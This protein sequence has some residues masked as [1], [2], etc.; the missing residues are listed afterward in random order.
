MEGQLR[1]DFTADSSFS[2]ATVDAAA[3]DNSFNDSGSGFPTLAAG[4]WIR[5][6]G[7]S[8]NPVNNGWHEVV[9]QVAG[10]IVVAGVTLIT[11]AVGDTITISDSTLVNGVV[12]KSYTLEKNMN[13]VTQFFGFTGC[14]VNTWSLVLASRQKVTGT[15]GVLGKAGALAATTL[16]S[17]AYTAAPTNL[18]LNASANVARLFEGGAV[19]G[20]GVFA[21][22][23]NIDFNQNLRVVDGIGQ[24]DAVDIG[25][26][27]FNTTG[28]LDALFANEVLFNKYMNSTESAINVAIEDAAG[29][30]YMVSFPAVV[31][32]NGDIV[33]VGNDDQII[34][35]MEWEAKMHA[36]QGIMARIDRTP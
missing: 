11:E 23:I 30:G 12:K 2:A 9:S 5:V 20:A 19:L 29:N 28:T 10:K 1:S 27:R 15:F 34:A 32:T 14:R 13:D 26:G 25:L 31:Y 35:S 7:F 8:T 21:Q 17:G 36:T 24:P 18:I 4:Q 6:A 16:G 3:A 22:T 33:G